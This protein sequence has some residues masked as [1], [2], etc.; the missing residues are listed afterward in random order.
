MH[1]CFL[2]LHCDFICYRRLESL[3]WVLQR[4]GKS[5]QLC[6]RL[7]V[8]WEHENISVQQ[9]MSILCVGDWGGGGIILDEV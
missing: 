7:E 4:E 9:E 1:L 2:Y 3:V 5:Q 8:S 6:N